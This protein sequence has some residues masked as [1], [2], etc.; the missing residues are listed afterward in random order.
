MVVNPLDPF[1]TDAG[2]INMVQVPS[3]LSCD[4]CPRR[5]SVI[6]PTNRLKRSCSSQL[7]MILLFSNTVGLAYQ[8]DIAITPWTF[9]SYV[10]IKTFRQNTYLFMLRGF[11]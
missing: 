11:S 8:A 5:S 2:V 1:S 9:I 4:P 6:L 10:H 7:T 3:A